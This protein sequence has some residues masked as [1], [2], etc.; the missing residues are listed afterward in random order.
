MEK[1][2]LITCCATTDHDGY[3]MEGYATMREQGHRV[4]GKGHRV[5][6]PKCI[7]IYPIVDS[8]QSILGY[9]PAVDGMFTGCGARLIASPDAPLIDV[10]DDE[11]W[12]RKE[13]TLAAAQPAPAA[14]PTAAQ[15]APTAA[16]PG[17]AGVAT[18]A[19]E[20]ARLA[21][22][23]HVV[24]RIFVA[25]DGTGNNATNSAK[26]LETCSVEKVLSKKHNPDPHPGLLDAW[27]A[28]CR[29][30]NKVDSTSYVGGETN[31]HRLFDLCRVTDKISDA[32]KSSDGRLYVNLKTYVEGI[33]TEAD[34]D[35][36][37][38]GSALGWGPTGVIARAKLGIT[39]S[40]GE[41]RKFLSQNPSTKIVI[42]AIEFDLV[43]FSRG[44][45]ATR[46]LAN[47]IYHDGK[48]GIG[49][50]AQQLRVAGLPFKPE[51]GKDKNDLR[52]RFIG[53]FETV[54]AIGIPDNGNN[55]P[56]KLYLADEI[57]DVVVHLVAADEC[58]QN[59]ALNPI[60][61]RG[62]HSQIAIPGVHSDVGGGYAMLGWESVV[63]TPTQISEEPL[64]WE[65]YRFYADVAER[66][67]RP[68]QLA[69]FLD[70]I[71]RES[72]AWKRA[73]EL[74]QEA[75]DQ[76]ARRPDH[77]AR[78]SADWLVDP[79]LNPPRRA[80]SATFSEDA[81]RMQ[82]WYQVT[83]A[84]LRGSA[85]E[86]VL[87]VMAA[88]VALRQVRGEYQL[89]PLRLMHALA[90]E[91]GVAFDFIDDSDP[92]YALPGELT[93]I[94]QKLLIYARNGGK[95]GLPLSLDE[96]WLL[97]RRYLHQSAHWTPMAWTP[98]YTAAASGNAPTVATLPKPGAGPA[99]IFPMRP[100]DRRERL[101]FDPKP[102]H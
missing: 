87:Q 69:N 54:A 39:K 27:Q 13:K 46:H 90:Q 24:L 14:A 9:A 89:I 50:A 21:D 55:D 76:D 59:F 68:D 49:Y 37:L 23:V 8:L 101:V 38:Y 33:G 80:G 43:G 58:R 4:A 31:V 88:L 91:G 35:D 75:I 12:L 83:S 29:K 6:C 73:G 17:E 7:G 16:L 3:V 86:R 64:D 30:L 44:A 72:R 102:G 53:L 56:V 42:D 32:D 5:Y 57:A 28:D 95:G 60:V 25:N 74:W 77:C 100:A 11:L 99:L 94:L 22:A 92:K 20:A 84:H 93:P 26:A 78:Q 65:Q 62:R 63:L 85:G 10:P 61:R 2:K 48:P 51:W 82:W 66:A 36:S 47:L 71:A 45:A 79:Q 52:I 98:T 19:F 15:P 81:L 96:K 67:N 18:A 97:S 40:I 1:R 34:S 70:A 41:I